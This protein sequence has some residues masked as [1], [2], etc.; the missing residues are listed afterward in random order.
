[1]DG[2]VAGGLTSTQPLVSLRE[3]ARFRL[4]IGRP[5]CPQLVQA[6]AEVVARTPADVDEPKRFAVADV[7][8]LEAVLDDR[9]QLLAGRPGPPASCDV[10][11]RHHD[12]VDHIVDAAIG[13]NAHHV[14]RAI[15]RGHLPLDRAER[16]HHLPDIAVHVAVDEVTGQVA[17]RPAAVAVA[18][19]DQ[20][21]HRRCERPD[22]QVLVEEQR[23]NVRA[24]EEIAHVAAGAR[25]ILVP[26]G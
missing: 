24:V 15:L 26:D 7:D 16:P 4:N 22:P 14:G 2:F 17:D 3:G 21:R 10:D 20:V 5:Q 23:C 13:P 8:F 9:P 19:I 18:N 11:E 1:M 12:S 25:K 6:V